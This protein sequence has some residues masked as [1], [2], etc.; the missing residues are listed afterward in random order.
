MEHYDPRTRTKVALKTKR[1][2]TNSL[3]AEQLSQLV[4]PNIFL[5]CSLLAAKEWILDEHATPMWLVLRLLGS[6][7]IGSL[8]WMSFAGRSPPSDLEWMTIGGSAFLTFVQQIAVYIMLQRLALIVIQA[9]KA[10][11]DSFTMPRKSPLSVFAI[12]LS[13]ASSCNYSLAGVSHILPAYIALFFHALS[14]NAL[15][16]TWKHSDSVAASGK[17]YIQAITITLSFVFS[18]VFYGLGRVTT[19]ISEPVILPFSSFY[20]I[21]FI[22]VSSL[23]LFPK[24]SR[25]TS[26]MIAPWQFFLLSLL[27][28]TIFSM[29]FGYLAFH[30]QFSFVDPIVSGLLI[31]GSELS[32]PES[33]RPSSSTSRLL[34]SY[35]KTILSNPESR[36]I[37]Y[38]LLLNLSYMGIQVAYGIITN[39]LGLISDAIHMAFDC[40]AIA[41]GLFASVAATWMPNE[42]YT[43]GY[44]RIETLS[45]FANGIFLLLISIFIIFE[46]IQRLLDPPEMSTNQLLLVSSLGLAVNLFGMFAMGGHHHHGGH[47]HSHG[48]HSHGDHNHSSNVEPSHSH[49]NSLPCQHLDH[50]H[51]HS[52]SHTHTRIHT[53]IHTHIHPPQISQP[54]SHNDNTH[55]HG[56]NHA[57]SSTHSH[58][59][60]SPSISTSGH[61]RTISIVSNTDLKEIQQQP[62]S[63]ISPTSPTLVNG[64]RRTVSHV[65]G[66]GIYSNSSHLAVLE[67][68][69]TPVTPNYEFGLD[70]HFTEHHHSQHVPNLHDHSHHPPVHEGHSHNMRGVFLHVMA[71]TL[72]S[73]G[74]IISTLLIQ[75]YGWTGFD[76]IASLFIAVLIAASVLPLVIDS[77]RVLSLSIDGQRDRKIQHILQELNNIDGVESY[78]QARFW[79]KDPSKLVGSIHIQLAPRMP[80]DP[81]GPHSARGVTYASIDRVLE[82][83]DTLLRNRITGLD[84]LTI[85]VEGSMKQ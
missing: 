25:S 11:F 77:G 83:V 49:G 17:G 69:D 52:H 7:T 84:E 56:P 28:T 10:I 43:Y 65:N 39:S 32:D 13:F 15:E 54:H 2:L 46:A 23:Y 66:T 3:S 62:L 31:Y 63:P 27:S 45:G 34:D 14:T 68:P 1:I 9:S 71:D 40:I 80:A 36:K 44:G 58:L 55:S 50:S 57:R 12:L 24:A 67:S 5:V 29:L 42:Q 70:T 73:V 51:T 64:H 79:P 81:T 61:R 75:F 53:H 20:P 18:V 76:P 16:T 22:A 78:S 8:A 59:S 19:L 82:N 38:F 85:Q 35:L 41:M 37:F 47:S 26:S 6:G 33:I 74:V 60:P 48:G 30:Q 4:V 21:P 72:G